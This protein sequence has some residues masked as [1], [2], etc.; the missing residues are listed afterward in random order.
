MS[1]ALWSFLTVAGPIVLAIAIIVAILSNRR[2]RAEKE[3]SE[4]A[5]RNQHNA[6]RRKEG[7]A[8]DI[9]PIRPEGS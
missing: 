7:V 9:R 4:R 3:F 1:G 6:E 2:S 5:V 8:P